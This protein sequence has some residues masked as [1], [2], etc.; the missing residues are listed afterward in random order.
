[1]TSPAAK[2]DKKAR[3]GLED[4]LRVERLRINIIS[5]TGPAIDIPELSRLVSAGEHQDAQDMARRLGL[6]RHPAEGIYD[7]GGDC[8]KQAFQEQPPPH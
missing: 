8:R 2:P 5:T 7:G 6:T 1:M 4:V 3:D